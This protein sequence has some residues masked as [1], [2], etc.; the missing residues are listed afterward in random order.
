[1]NVSDIMT[2]KP[3]TIHQDQTL[4]RALEIMEAHN[5]RHLPVLNSENQIVGILS[6]RDCRTALNSPFIMRERWQDEELA[7]NLL[8]RSMMTPAPIVIEPDATADEAARLMLGN[9]ISCLPVILGETL[10]GIVTTSDIMMAFMTMYKR[11]KRIYD[12]P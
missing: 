1:M 7:N 10:V 3:M 8:V 5:C 2:A 4:R 11:L 6:D 9:H 12:N